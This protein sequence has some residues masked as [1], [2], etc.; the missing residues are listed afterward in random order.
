MNTETPRDIITLWTAKVLG[1]PEKVRDIGATFKFIV[2]GK[3]GGT[4]RVQCKDPV[5]VTEGDGPA[6]CTVMV[7]NDDFVSLANKKLNP[8]V[9]FM[10]GKIKLSGD[11]SLALKL[12]EF[13]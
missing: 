1:A 10:M 5:A 9:A 4:W 8:Q 12:G 11:L 2:E 13:I 3:D 7:K 6:D